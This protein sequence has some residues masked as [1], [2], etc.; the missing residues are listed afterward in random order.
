MLDLRLDL[1]TGDKDSTGGIQPTEWVDEAQ[2]P[3][4][5]ENA[6]EWTE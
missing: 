6:E 2:D 4:V 5:D 3:W 1:W